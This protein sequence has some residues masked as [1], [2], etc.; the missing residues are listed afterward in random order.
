MIWTLLFIWIGVSLP[1]QT[2]IESPVSIGG[3]LGGA[4]GANEV[5][6]RL[7]EWG[8]ASGICALVQDRAAGTLGGELNFWYARTLSTARESR[9][10][11]GGILVDVRG[12]AMMQLPFEIPTHAF[13]SAGIGTIF[14][15]NEII[16]EKP[17]SPEF[18]PNTP[19]LAFPLAVGVRAMVTEKLS[20]ELRATY[21]LTTTD[22]LNAPHDG[23][24]DGL[25]ALT[26]GVVVPI[27]F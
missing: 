11:T 24:Y 2:V 13:A 20:L 3:F 4:R 25:F 1:A 17:P 27:G 21:V 5:P 14:P 8:I 12:R 19:A 6:A 26:L 22:N 10:A 16:L 18:E 7:Q 23:Q 9:Y 15:L